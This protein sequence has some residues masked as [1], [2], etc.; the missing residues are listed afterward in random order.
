[1]HLQCDW[2]LADEQDNV[3]VVVIAKDK[4]KTNRIENISNLEFLFSTIVHC[5]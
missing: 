2:Q 4:K 3:K 1:M 5:R